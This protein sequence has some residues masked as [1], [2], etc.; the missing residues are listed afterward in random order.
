MTQDGR[1]LANRPL[2][3]LEKTK[4]S[5]YWV[6]FDRPDAREM[7]L[8]E[9]RYPFVGFAVGR[10]LAYL[11]HPKIKVFEDHHYLIM[12]AIEADKMVVKEL[13]LFIGA[14]FLITYH[15]EKLNFLA[16]IERMIK[17]EETGVETPMDVVRLMIN[18]L[19][20]DYYPIV[21]AC[22]DRILAIEENRHHRPKGT[23][24][25]EMFAIRRQLLKLSYSIV[26]MKDL[27]FSILESDKFVKGAKNYYFFHNVYD[28]LFRLSEL[29]EANE[30]AIEILRDN[31]MTINAYRTNHIT[32][33]LTVIGT[34]FIPLT[35]LAGVYGMNFR[36]IPGLGGR[37]SFHIIVLVMCLIGWTLYA[38]FRRKGWFDID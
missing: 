12:H 14:G 38:W 35:F 30:K 7:A 13:D 3:D 29:I 18:E 11:R 27:M 33:T 22:G 20:S 8:L 37:Y 34:I 2:E 32:K 16:E 26:P 5:W 17:H 23:M 10:H 6:D 15:K 4:V 31:Y 21:A 19:V 25:E 28:H 24:I 9:K 1:L 36:H